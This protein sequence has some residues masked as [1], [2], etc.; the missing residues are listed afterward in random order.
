MSVHNAWSI[1]KPPFLQ[2]ATEAVFE[3]KA[4]LANTISTT[5]GN[6]WSSSLVVAVEEVEVVAPVLVSNSVIIL[7]FSKVVQMYILTVF[8]S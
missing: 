4:Y 5:L 1:E 6:R 3:R 7:A 2:N 8:L